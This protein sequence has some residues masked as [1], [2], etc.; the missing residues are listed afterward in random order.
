M[1]SFFPKDGKRTVILLDQ[2]DEAAS[3]PDLK[4]FVTS[5]ATDSHNNR[6][7]IVLVVTSNKQLA[8]ALLKM[9]GGRKIVP[10]YPD[11]SDPPKWT[12]PKI[13]AQLQELVN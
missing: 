4:I 7:F 12:E 3:N 8:D 11:N 13:A 6:N 2:F 10:V 9:N 5:L 1:S